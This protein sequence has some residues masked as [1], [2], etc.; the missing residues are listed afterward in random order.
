MLYW[1]N[2]SHQNVSDNT[3][4]LEKYMINWYKPSKIECYIEYY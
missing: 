3:N 4:M 2:V 1:K